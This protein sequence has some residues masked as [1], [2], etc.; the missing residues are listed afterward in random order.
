[1]KDEYSRKEEVEK[2]EKQ[3][4]KSKIIHEVMF[5]SMSH[6]DSS[7]IKDKVQYG[8]DDKAKQLISQK[9]S[10]NYGGYNRIVHDNKF[11]LARRGHGDPIGRYPEYVKPRERA[12]TEAS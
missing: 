9:K 2:Q 5:K 11:K 12:L 6:G 1:M 4:W 8:L 7:F 10:Y 3:Q